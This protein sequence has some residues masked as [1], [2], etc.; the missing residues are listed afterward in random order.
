MQLEKDELFFISRARDFNIEEGE[1]HPRTKTSWRGK[2]NRATNTDRYQRYISMLLDIT[3]F[4]QGL[5]ILD[6]G[7]GVGAEILELSYLG[8][9]CVG[10]DTGQSNIR[11][12]KAVKDHFKLENPTVIYGNSCGLPFYDNTFDVVMSFEFFEHVADP[13]LAMKEQMRVLKPG[14]RFII[15]QANFLDPLLL[16]NLLIRSPLRNHHMMGGLRWLFTKGKV[17]RN[18]GGL[19]WE[20]KDEDVHSRLWWRG[21]IKQYPDLEIIEFSSYIGKMRGGFFKMLEHFTGNILIVA[22]KR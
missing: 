2:C 21:K 18:Y 6:V 19:G 17:I 12:I 4:R 1:F 10:L 11:L 9:D 14:G 7:C 22:V 13:H 15:E 20:G 8:A 5:K 16:F 3:G